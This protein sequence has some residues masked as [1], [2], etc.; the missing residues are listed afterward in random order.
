MPHRSEQATLF[1]LSPGDGFE[2]VGGLGFE[3]V[4]PSTAQESAPSTPQGNV[5]PTERQMFRAVSWLANMPLHEVCAA[6]AREIKGSGFVILDYDE[7]GAFCNQD[8]GDKR[9]QSY[10]YEAPEQGTL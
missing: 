6:C 5:A 2:A 1:E 7:L 4:S 8:C 10:L 9:F 3:P